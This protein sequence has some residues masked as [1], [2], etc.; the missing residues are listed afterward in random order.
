[1]IESNGAF[2]KVKSRSLLIKLYPTTNNLEK[3]LTNKQRYQAK[4]IGD[5]CSS[6]IIFHMMMHFSLDRL[7]F[8]H[9]VVFF[10]FF[11]E[12]IAK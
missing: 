6:V 1:M 9:L 10:A 4:S 8:I 7:F 5:C 2:V 11:V 12:I 3:K